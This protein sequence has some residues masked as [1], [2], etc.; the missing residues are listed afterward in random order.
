MFKAWLFVKRGFITLLSYKTAFTLGILG[1]FIGILQFSFMGKFLSQGNVFPSIDQYGGNLLAYLIIG[2]AFTSFLGVSLNSFQ[3]AIRSEQQMGTLEYLLMSNTKLELLLIFSGIWNF[4]YTLFNISFLLAIVV[5]VFQVPLEINLF[6][7][8]VTL[9]LT[10]ISLSG[11]GLM[12]AGVIIVTK[13]GDPVT[14]IF[15]SLTG[16]LSGVL[17]PVEFLP[18]YLR[19]IS[20]VLPTTHALHALRLTLIENA[21]FTEI[22]PQILFLTITAMISVPLGFFVF[23][24]G[25]NTARRSGTLV[26]Y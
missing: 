11:I 19:G 24:K 1:S 10:I 8:G 9:L 18:F 25:F 6:A 21:S 2:S 12:S 23:R 13:M 4:V 15:T 17:F 26:E 5:L 7:A 16:L 20:Y 14:W 22:L 3:G